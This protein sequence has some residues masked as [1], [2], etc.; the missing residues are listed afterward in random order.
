MLGVA[1]ARRRQRGHERANPVSAQHTAAS[2]YAG[3]GLMGGRGECRR[4]CARGPD[5]FTVPWS[6]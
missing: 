3:G 1:C 4:S 2:S 6:S 5:V